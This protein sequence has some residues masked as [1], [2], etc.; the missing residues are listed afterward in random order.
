MT[1]YQNVVTN[2]ETTTREAGRVKWFNNKSGYGFITRN[3]SNDDIFVHHSAIKVEQEQYKYLVQGEYVEFIVV[4]TTSGPHKYQAS[5]VVGVS[6]GKLM[7]E[8]KREFKIARSTYKSEKSVDVNEEPVVVT[9]KKVE[10]PVR[11]KPVV[12]GRDKTTSSQDNKAE[13][14]L[15]KKDQ[16]NDKQPVKKMRRTTPVNTGASK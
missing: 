13:W 9:Q 1:T 5:S 7:C 4:E 2:H 10:T 8:T 16:S 3:S 12:R 11:E 6:G 15:V 14:T